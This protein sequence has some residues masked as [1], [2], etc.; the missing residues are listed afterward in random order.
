MTTRFLVVPVAALGI[1]GSSVSWN[2]ARKEGKGSAI[3][4][5]PTAATYAVALQDSAYTYVG[6]KKCKICHIKEYKSWEKS[7]MGQAFETLKPGN[8]A[9]TKK[10]FNIDL[11]KDYTTDANCLKCHTTGFGLPGGYAIPDPDDKKAVRKAKTL[12]GVG[13]ESCHGPGSACMDVFKDLFRS[14][15]KY[16]VEELYAV[17]LTKIGES[18]CTTCH[19]AESPTINPDDPFDYEKQKVEGVHDRF[20][21]KQRQ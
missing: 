6:S 18:T 11:S 15:R 4:A 7:E 5:A 19:N 21:L 2:A 9:E 12:E 20:P 13:C 3:A 10:K 17:G 1:L 14:K 16:N 8:A